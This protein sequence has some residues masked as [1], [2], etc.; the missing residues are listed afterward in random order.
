MKNIINFIIG[1]FLMVG[2]VKAQVSNTENYIRTK[3]YLDYPIG[4]SPK[5]TETVQYFD[6]LGRP[7]QVVNVKASP[8]GKDMV[9]HIEYD[10]FGRLVKDYLPVPQAATQNGAIYTSPLGN[11]TSVYGGEKI[12]SEKVLEDSPLD[13]IQQQIQ[14]GNDWLGKP[15]TTEYDVNTLADGVRKFITTTSWVNGATRSVLAE[16]WL[17]RIGELYKHSVTDEDGNKTIEFKNS[18]GQTVVIRKVINGSENADTHYV[19]NEYNQ[20]AFVIPPLAS[21]RGDIVA[22]TLKHD[23]FCYQYRYDGKNRL[24]EKKFPGK[25]WEYMIY[26]KQDRLVATQDANLREKGQWLYTKYDQFSRVIMTGLSQEA[27]NSRVAEQN[28]ADTKG[29]NNETRTSTVVVNY[30]GMAVYYTVETGYPQYDKVKYLL[31][32]NYY[33]SYP[34]GTPVI[35]TQILGQDV[36]QQPGQGSVSTKGLPLVNLVKNIEDDNWTKNYTYYDA[37]GRIIGI[38]SINHLGGYTRTESRLDFIGIPQQSITRHKRLDSDAERMI[39]ET[40]EYDSQKRLKKHWHQIDGNTPEL[41]AENTYNELSQLTNKKVGNNL[42][43]I[44]YNYNIRGWLTKINDPSNLNGKLFGYSMKYNAPLTEGWHRKYNGTISEVDWASQSDNILKRYVYMY[45]SLNHLTGGYYLEPNSSILWTGTF[46]EYYKY[47]LNSNITKLIRLG[48]PPVSQITPLMID[49]LSYTYEGNKL[50]SVSDLSQNSSGYPI[51]GKT[52][53]YDDNG[54]MVNHLDKGIGSVKYNFLDLPNE[55]VANQMLVAPYS[56]SY[57]YRADGTKVGKKEKKRVMDVVGNFETVE[58]VTDYLNGFQY[59]PTLSFGNPSAIKLQL[60]PT[61]EGY[62]DFDKNL[63]IYNYT[64]HLGNIRVSFARNS[65]GALEMVNFNDYYPYG[66]SHLRM[67]SF[68]TAEGS[69]KYKFLGNEQQETGWYDMNARFYMPDL[70]RFGQHDPLSSSTLETYGYALGNPVNF[71]DPFGTSPLD[72]NQIGSLIQYGSGDGPGI[73]K[74]SIGGS[75]N[76]Y[77]I[78][79]IVLNAPIRAMVSNPGSVMPS[80]CSVCYSG[81]GSSSGINLLAPQIR[82]VQPTFTSRGPENGQGGGLYMMSGDMFGFSDLL[83]IIFSN[84]KSEN[85]EAALGLAALAVITTKGKAAKGIVKVELAAEKG[86][87]S[88]ADWTSYPNAIPKPTGPFRILEGAEYEAARKA[89]NKANQAMRRAD[90]ETY[91]GLEIH[92]IHP[93]KYGGSATDPMNKIAIP[94]DYHRKVVTPW[95]NDNMISIKKIP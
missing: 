94:R 88:V 39:T 91:K 81:N 29:K 1:L 9:T 83:G 21:I 19:Y 46:S 16:D 53:A 20:L 12:F 32:L 84:M 7:K 54:N 90:P 25:G 82:N 95:W 68:Y 2:V 40:F 45:D 18:R 30:S 5:I 86:A 6:G 26:D 59:S 28:Y 78:P 47:D 70:G 48:R 24:V 72:W 64:D 63:Y 23:E 89:A 31:S 56:L 80:Y 13:R 17:Y 74:N 38:H 3:T 57:T 10:H 11:A 22:N 62:Y 49:D 71:S 67:G 61:A 8:Q 60:V 87:F 14:V 93:V 69:Y 55:V 42:Q 50:K 27:G 79:E 66:M 41:L 75:N 73:P 37:K 92:E 65:A 35:P 85:R 44:D 52:I 77:Q 51:G 15:I 33:D 76:P 4:L 43:S 36:L 58:I 34:P